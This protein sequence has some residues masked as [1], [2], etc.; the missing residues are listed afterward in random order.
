M[1]VDEVVDT[2]TRLMEPYARRLDGVIVAGGGADMVYGVLRDRW[3]HAIK[4]ED[5]RFSVAEGM[6]RFGAALSLVRAK[7]A[8]PA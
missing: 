5:P 4:A 7:L 3:P 1:L 6:R 2:A 8:T